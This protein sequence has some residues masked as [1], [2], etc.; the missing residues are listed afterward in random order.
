MQ[1]T[2][3]H[4]LGNDFIMVNA[5]DG[6]V[7]EELGDLSRAAT[8]LCRRQFSI[9]ADGL[10]LILP[11]DSAD[12]R[13]RIFNPDGSEAEMCGNGIRCFA[14]Y[15]LDKGVTAKKSITVE[16]L[17]GI[18]K[19]AIL[20]GGMVRVDMG[21]P[22]LDRKKIGM[23]GPDTKVVDEPLELEGKEVRITAVSMG[24]PHAVVFVDTFNFSIEDLGREIERHEKFPNRTN[25]EFVQ[26]VN[27][28]ELDMCVWERGAGVT[29]ACGT[30]ACAAAVAAALNDKAGRDV[31][32]H[33][34]GGDLRIEWKE[35][36]NHVYM[37]GPAE[38]VF[39]GVIDVAEQL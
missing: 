2:K 22:V 35:G 27:D 10:I 18:M 19:P 5:L 9:G 15:L 12:Y 31:T 3:M 7:V 38:T 33:L 37:T 30:G 16:T 14:K 20:D 1:F 23:L 32:V 13:M 21:E 25:V 8:K 26:P 17:A 36:D 34:L 4:G 39:E 29:L 11:S 6:E 28:K 24:N